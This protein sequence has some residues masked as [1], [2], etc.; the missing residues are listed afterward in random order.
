ME[1]K[2]PVKVNLR[3]HE[4]KITMI[5]WKRAN[6]IL[7][8]QPRHEISVWFELTPPAYGIISFGISL[9]VKNYS[10]KEF[11]AAAI[12]EGEKQ[13]QTI[14]LS[15]NKEMVEKEEEEKRAKELDAIVQ[16]IVD[17]LAV[18]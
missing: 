10:K 1:L 7:R 9:P 11:L 3:G 6:A 2:E 16:N 12:L 8:Q 13:L 17:R 18:G 5:S 14:A 4:A 15:H